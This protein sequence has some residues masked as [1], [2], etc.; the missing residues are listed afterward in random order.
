MKALPGLL[1]EYLITG[2][3]TLLMMWVSHSL[4]LLA[5][6]GWLQ[7]ISIG[8][9]MLGVLIPVTYVLGMIVD[10]LSKITMDILSSF[11]DDFWHPLVDDFIRARLTPI[12]WISS[13]TLNV[14]IAQLWVQYPD[15]SCKFRFSL[16]R[17]VIPDLIRDPVKY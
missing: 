1:I 7:P 4:G 16:R 14:F 6:P 2:S 13:T 8:P 12:T 5:L 10:F 11:V 3:C 17:L 9:T 15:Q